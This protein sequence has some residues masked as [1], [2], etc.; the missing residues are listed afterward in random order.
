MK[1]ISQATA[2]SLMACKLACLSACQLVSCFS[3]VNN[4]I[5][6]SNNKIVYKKYLFVSNLHFLLDK[7]IFFV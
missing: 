2:E 4:S 3:F 5:I 1:I 6:I 7:I